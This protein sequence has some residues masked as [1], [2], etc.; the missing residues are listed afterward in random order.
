MKT[1]SVS[2]YM[3]A[4]ST[5]NI[6]AK[7]QAELVRAQKEATTGF[8]FD[9]G[10]ALGSRTG[11]SISLRKEHD[12]LTVLTETNG[13]IAERMTASQ[14]ALSNIIKGSQGFL[15]DVTA[16]RGSA[17]GRAIIVDQAKGLLQ[18]ATDLV[19][20]TY[21]GEYIFAG[22]N[23][24]VKP[25][26]DYGAAGDPARAAVLQSFQDYFGFPTTDPQV[27]NI[28]AAD[29]K[30]YLDTS[31]AAE[32]DAGSW[33]TNFS[34]A[35]DTLV[36]SRIAPTELAETSVSANNAGFRQLAMSYTMIAEFGDIGLNQTAF[37]AVIDKAAATTMQT[38]TS[39]AGAQSFL[40]NAQGRTKDATDRLTVQI[41][42]LNSSVLDLEAVDPYEAA[43]RVEALRTQIDA[44][45]ALTVKIQ[46]LSLLNYLK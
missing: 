39:L 45:Y 4:N 35:S 29:M 40:G 5:R 22:E 17:T 6:L 30:D 34:S 3:L 24:D 11:Q 13:V 46:S 19:N 21:N 31:F 32:F 41:N 8:V 25:L 10:L 12:R 28:T 42:V 37:D 2:S 44:S 43:N 36:K 1:Q 23:T 16:M 26:G 14:N 7:A 9:T 33:S 38:T 27:A 15:G 20:T 18:T